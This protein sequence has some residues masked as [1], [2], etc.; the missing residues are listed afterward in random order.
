MVRRQ[1]DVFS[2]RSGAPYLLYSAFPT[3]DLSEYG[4][5]PV[6]HPP[7]MVRAPGIAV[8]T[9]P[10]AAGFSVA[11]VESPEQL[12]DFE[13]TFVE[14]Y[15]VP[16]LLP[17]TPGVFMGRQLIEHPRWNLFVG[18]ADGTPVATSAAFVTDHAIDVTL[19]ACRPE[20][21]GRGYGRT[22]T[23]AAANVERSK[24]ALLLASDDGQPVYRSMGFSAMTRF[25]LWIG[26][27]PSG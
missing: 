9:R 6:G 4:L 12:D 2:R 20:V 19:V 16:D 8:A 21:R 14:A 18:Y 25:S 7:C 5:L 23:E 13:R 3:P 22:L 11:R 17:W 15:P 26:T 10:N 27:R 24:P 1:A